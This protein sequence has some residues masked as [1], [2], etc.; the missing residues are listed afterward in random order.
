MANG[1]KSSRVNAELDKHLKQL[2]QDV[3]KPPKEG[4]TNG[5]SL[6]DKMKVIDRMLKWES[7]KGKLND[8]DWGSGFG[9]E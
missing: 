3:M 2:L 9:D 8:G 7:I 6:T 1:T 5:P 4:D